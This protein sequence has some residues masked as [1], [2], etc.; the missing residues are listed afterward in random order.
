MCRHKNILTVKADDQEGV[1]ISL[2]LSGA[3]RVTVCP[4]GASA[5][6]RYKLTLDNTGASFTLDG[7]EL[8][9]HG[10]TVDIPSSMSSELVTY[11]EL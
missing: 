8:T 5:A 7:R 11:E 6:Q 10:I 9:M 3:R 1:V 4:K 2:S